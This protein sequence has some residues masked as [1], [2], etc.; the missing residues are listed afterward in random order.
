MSYRIVG[1]GAR[2]DGEP[3]PLVDYAN[4]DVF[5]RSSIA[6]NLDT[7]TLTWLGGSEAAN[8]LAANIARL[9]S[10]GAIL[11]VG[12][13]TNAI[14]ASSIIDDGLWVKVNSPTIGVD[15]GNA[16]DLGADADDLIHVATQFSQIQ[17][18]T[19]LAA[20]VDNGPAALSVWHQAASG[21][22]GWRI[23]AL[24]RAS[25][26]NINNPRTATT[27]WQRATLL[28]ADLDSGANGVKMALLNESAGGVK[29]VR[30]WGNN[31]VADF[32]AKDHIETPSG[33]T[34]TQASEDA[35]FNQVNWSRLKTGDFEINVHPLWSTTDAPATG[36]RHTVYAGNLADDRLDFRYT[37]TAW[38]AR[39]REHSPMVESLVTGLVFGPGDFVTLRVSRSTGKLQGSVN[40]G[41]FT[42]GSTI[43]AAGWTSGGQ[44]FVGQDNANG[45]H[46]D[47]VLEQPTRP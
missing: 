28:I 18:Q 32:Y 47:G 45:A 7:R 11:I 9:F 3:G 31:F 25:V 19:A 40:G 6:A 26:Q 12:S 22:I 38:E 15:A 37:G 21:S 13:W 33:S 30:H 29:T 24:D 36:T 39:Y 2:A 20:T 35:R 16:P 34:A 17:Q 1:I 5:T 41:G 4:L 14:T 43:T 23:G 27:T 46:I 8:Y 44:L 42:D 10:D